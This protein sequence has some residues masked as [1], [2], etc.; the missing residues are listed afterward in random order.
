MPT[1]LWNALATAPAP[2]VGPGTPAHFATVAVVAVVSPGLFTAMLTGALRRFRAEPEGR[3]T[4]GGVAGF[5]A[6]GLLSWALQTR[7]LVQGGAGASRPPLNSLLIWL[8]ALA[9]LSF[10]VSAAPPRRSW[11]PSRLLDG[12]IFSLAAYLG[13]WMALLRPL[14]A[15]HPVPLGLLLATHGVFALACAGLGNCLHVLVHRGDPLRSPLG[16]LALGIALC[17]A[18]LPWWVSVQIQGVFHFGHPVR[19]ALI[20]GF[21]VLA[22]APGLPW[23]DTLKPRRS[24]AFLL[25]YLPASAAFIGF[26]VQTFRAPAPRDP[27]GLALLGALALL[28]LARQALTLRQLARLNHTLEARVEART[29]ELTRSQ[30]LLLETQQKNMIATLGAGL[31]H[32]FNNLLGAALGNLDLIRLKHPGEDPREVAALEQ[33]LNRASDLSK[34]LM[35]LAREGETSSGTFHLNAHLAD[36][37][38]LLRAMVPRSIQLECNPGEEALEVQGHPGQVDQVVVNLVSNAKDATPQ[39]GTISLRARAEGPEA[40][41]EVSDTGS[42]IDPDVMPRLFEPFLTT[43]PVGKGTGLG[44]SSVRAV[45]EQLGG[46]IEV[47]SQPGEGTTFTVRLPRASGDGG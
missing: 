30:A 7:A 3:L 35:N 17:V 39:G 32:D 6:V 19:L 10:A 37:Q 24:L 4:W 20:P 47:R 45:V 43:K 12:A 18:C 44:L 42:G 23:P 25:P 1:T 33:A 27:V 16:F 40:L 14:F 31:S 5:A 22:L 9:M 11:S 2:G 13:L 46:R 38:P 41:I 36:L 34:R 21:I 15:S 8:P 29:Q 26:L 28:V